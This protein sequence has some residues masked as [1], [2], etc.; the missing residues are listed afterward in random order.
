MLRYIYS[1]QGDRNGNR[2]AFKEKADFF[3]KDISFGVKFF[4]SENNYPSEIHVK[5]PEIC[6]KKKRPLLQFIEKM[7]E[8]FRSEKIGEKEANKNTEK[9]R[10]KQRN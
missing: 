5:L 2:G 8:N 3:P 9:V 7:R 1:E 10:D 4:V 6:F